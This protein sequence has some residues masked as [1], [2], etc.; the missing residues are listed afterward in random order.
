MIYIN[1]LVFLAK[2]NIMIEV[3]MKI[4]CLH[5]SFPDYK[6]KY[7]NDISIVTSYISLISQSKMFFVGKNTIIQI[8]VL[9]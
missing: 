9:F 5:D 1:L 3:I 7:V 6:M 8:D 2:L 4:T